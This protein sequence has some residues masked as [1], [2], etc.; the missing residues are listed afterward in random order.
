VPRKV[1]VA[2]GGS[3]FDLIEAPAENEHHLQEV[4]KYSPTLLPVDDLGITGPLL[5]A[6]PESQRRVR[7]YRLGRRRALWRPGPG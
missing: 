6:G 2:Q 4:M 7:Q 1:L 3:T 5:V